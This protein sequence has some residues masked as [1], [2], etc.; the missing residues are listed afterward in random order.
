[1]WLSCR[2]RRAGSI[3][4]QPLPIYASRHRRE[5]SE[6]RQR[7]QAMVQST[8]QKMHHTSDSSCFYSGNAGQKVQ[9]GPNFFGKIAEA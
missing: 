7:K 3:N 2:R 6:C 9:P 5:G 8:F 4:W 1:M